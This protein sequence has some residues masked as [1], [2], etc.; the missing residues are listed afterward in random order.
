[1]FMLVW[2]KAIIE[3]V[4]EIANMPMMARNW[5]SP[6]EGVREEICAA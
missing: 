6:S 5:P 4:I 2:I 1:M 3:R